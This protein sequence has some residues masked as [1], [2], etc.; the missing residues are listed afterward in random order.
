MSND[1]LELDQMQIVANALRYE[2]GMVLAAR[3]ASTP[4][5]VRDYRMLNAPEIHTASIKKTTD[6][7][8]IAVISIRTDDLPRQRRL[9]D[10]FEVFDE[11]M[12]KITIDQIMVTPSGTFSTFNLALPRERADPVFRASVRIISDH[13]NDIKLGL[14]EF[15]STPGVINLAGKN[16]LEETTKKLGLT[17]KSK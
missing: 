13:F 12:K 15:L 10:D 5:G 3:L 8:D 2:T 7:S 14:T 6:G 9:I 1:Y 16:A 4:D 11:N 17:S